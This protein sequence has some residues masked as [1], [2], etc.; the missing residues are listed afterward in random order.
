MPVNNLL[1]ADPLAKSERAFGAHRFTNFIIDIKI[2]N[3]KGEP[4]AEWSCTS[5]SW[6]QF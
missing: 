2:F 5:L 6:F 1:L 4:I 3:G